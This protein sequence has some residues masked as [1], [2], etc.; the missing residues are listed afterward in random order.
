M[1]GK[2]KER[3]IFTKTETT[4][5]VILETKGNTNLKFLPIQVIYQ[6][7]GTERIT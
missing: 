4:V 3:K 1:D 5:K 2:G 6:L 7:M